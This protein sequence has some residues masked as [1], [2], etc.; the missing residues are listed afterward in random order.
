M[1]WFVE[2]VPRQMLNPLYRNLSRSVLALGETSELKAIYGDSQDKRNPTMCMTP[3]RKLP[4]R[5][6]SPAFIARIY[7]EL[8]VLERRRMSL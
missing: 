5:T 8:I 7:M 2:N 3:P 4:T 1:D 6:G